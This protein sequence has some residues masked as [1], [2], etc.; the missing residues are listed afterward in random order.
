MCNKSL[1]KKAKGD[2]FLQCINRGYK[3]LGEYINRNVKVKLLCPEGHEWDV[4]PTSFKLGVSCRK[5]VGH[6]PEKR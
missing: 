5:C 2:L 6:C 4:I 3:V 1:K